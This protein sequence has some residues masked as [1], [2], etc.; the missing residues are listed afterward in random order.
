MTYEKEC[1]T[2]YLQM[3]LALLKLARGLLLAGLLSGALSS[4][5]AQQP[6]R[7]RAPKIEFTEPGTAETGPKATGST[8]ASEASPRKPS[9]GGLEQ[10]VRKPFEFFNGED[11]FGGISSP[12]PTTGRP[13]ALSTKRARELLD[14]KKNWVFTTPEDLYGLPSAEERLNVPEYDAN[15]ELKKPKTSLERYFEREEKRHAGS[16]TN[17]VKNDSLPDWLKP[18]D[19][20]DRL[21]SG[22]DDRAGD[23]S[24]LGPGKANSKHPSADSGFAGSLGGAFS[25]TEK[26]DKEFFNLGNSAFSSK[27]IVPDPAAAKRFQIFSDLLK[28]QS[29]ASPALAP[30]FDAAAPGGSVVSPFQSPFSAGVFGRD[31]LSPQ[32]APRPSSLPSVSSATTLPNPY[33]TTYAPAYA[34]PAS[35]PRSF[36]PVSVFELPRPKY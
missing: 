34:P 22:N 6:V 26:S 9:L 27:P 18:D 31:S 12:P 24:I 11:S 4:A 30:S 23:H 1:D 20:E 33:G 3:R 16:A 28:S 32:A 5:E 36:T 29:P 14:R 21:S 2:V 8:N 10:T 13:S 25:P 15:G 19:A 35:T 7:R 17:R